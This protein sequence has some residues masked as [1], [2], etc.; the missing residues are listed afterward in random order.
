MKLTGHKTEKA[1]LGYLKMTGKEN[2]QKLQLHPF[3]N[4]LIS[5]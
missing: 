5:K 4:K 2:A 1:F 3:F